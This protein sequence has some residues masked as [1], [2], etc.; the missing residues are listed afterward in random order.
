MQRGANVRM[1]RQMPL[2]ASNDD[3]PRLIAWPE[4]RRRIP[5]SRS[6]IWRR[7]RDGNFPAPIQISPG[8]VAWLD[9]DI[10][11]W[12]AAQKQLP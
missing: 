7:I 12:M 10:L 11:A 1:A 2:I 5:L 3:A 4:L 9:R 6:T 8:R